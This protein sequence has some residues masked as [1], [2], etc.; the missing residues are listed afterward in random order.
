MQMR[1]SISEKKIGVISSVG[2]HLFIFSLFLIA[3]AVGVSPRSDTIHVSLVSYS[4]IPK[5]GPLSPRKEVNSERIRP[6]SDNPVHDS[7]REV[8][9]ASP[10]QVQDVSSVASGKEG[11]TPSIAQG[12]GNAGDVSSLEGLSSSDYRI[13]D[14][15][16]GNSEGPKFLHQEKPVYP[17]LA[18]RLGREGRVVLRLF[19]DKHGVLRHVEIVQ[20]DEFGFTEAAIDAVKR[21]TFIPASTNGRHVDCRALLTVW[22][23]LQ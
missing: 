23:K 6:F 16:F 3:P 12:G 8:S 5:E 18:R 1:A 14:T 13:L 17:F 22:F 15:S 4:D 10:V 19:I 20:P 7:R 9:Y 2:L 21:S 11:T